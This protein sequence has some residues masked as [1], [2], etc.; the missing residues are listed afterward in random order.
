MVV[1]RSVGKSLGE[2][3]LLDVVESLQ[4]GDGHKDDDGLL[5][6]ANLELSSHRVRTRIVSFPVPSFVPASPTKGG[7]TWSEGETGRL[8]IPKNG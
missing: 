3:P 4:Q 2:V 5:S 7:G 8:R 6:V 1:E